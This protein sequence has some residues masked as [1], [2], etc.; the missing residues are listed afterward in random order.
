MEN[1][2]EPEH[3]AASEMETVVLPG[4]LAIWT[5]HS[6]MEEAATDPLIA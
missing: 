2:A 3:P 4:N 6:L 1:A 5:F